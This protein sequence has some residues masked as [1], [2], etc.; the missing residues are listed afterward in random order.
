MGETKTSNLKTT[1]WRKNHI[2]LVYRFEVYLYAKKKKKTEYTDKM[3]EILHL[4]I[5]ASTKQLTQTE[6]HTHAK[7]MLGNQTLM[8]EYKINVQRVNN[9]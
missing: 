5:L 7:K 3:I 1:Q 8:N 9:H 4:N 2:N 6:K